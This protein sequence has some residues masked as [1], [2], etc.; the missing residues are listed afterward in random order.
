MLLTS[1]KEK[2][3]LSHHIPEY[4]IEDY[5]TDGWRGRGVG[6]EVKEK[7]GKYLLTPA[8]LGVADS[9]WVLMYSVE[10]F[11]KGGEVHRGIRYS[12]EQIDKI[13]N[14]ISE[15]EKEDPRL[16]P[17]NE[18]FDSWK[19]TRILIGAAL[20]RFKTFQIEKPP[21][22][23]IAMVTFRLMYNRD[24]REERLLSCPIPIDPHAKK[25]FPCNLGT[26]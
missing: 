13:I 9:S 10:L 23:T 20:H 3:P 7:E 24:N 5:L 14:K 19:N 18:H 26:F 15:T 8:L 11:Y 17:L 21:E 2:I 22:G 1:C 4:K 6:L 16:Q 12:A 25:L